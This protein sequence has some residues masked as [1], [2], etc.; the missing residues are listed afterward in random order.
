MSQSESIVSIFEQK[1]AQA[2]DAPAIRWNGGFWS[3]RELNS[4]ANQL[5]HLLI[6]SGVTSEAPVGIF[7]LRSPQTLMAFLAV[8]KAGGAYVPLDPTYP[9]DRIKYYIEDAAMPCVLVDPK[10]HLRFPETAARILVLDEKLAAEKPDSNP[11]IASG[12]GSLAHILYTSGST[13]RP[14]GVLVE[15]RGIIRLTQNVDY[16]T[17]T[18]SDVFLQNAPLSF[19][20]SSF[21][22]WGAL[23][24]GAC[25]AVPPSGKSTLS[26][27]ASAIRSFGITTTVMS[28]GLFHLL[29]EQELDSL[30]SLK[31]LITGGEVVSPSHAE[32]FLQRYPQAHLLNAYGP[33]ENSVFSTCHDIR[34]EKPMPTRLS[35]GRPIKGGGV[36]ILDDQL[37]PVKAGE[38]GELVLTGSGLARGYLNQPE[39]TAQ[40]FVQVTDAAGQSVRAY[41][42]GDLGSFLPDGSIDFHG[43]KDDQVKINGLRIEPGEIRNLLQAYPGVSAAEVMPVE[44]GGRK[45][46]EIFA[47]LRPAARVDERVLREFLRSKVPGNW[48][49]PQIR[50]LP[51]MPLN[52]NGKVD[53]AALRTI[54]SNDARSTAIIRLDEPSD[55]VEKLVWNVWREVLPGVRI[56][57][58]DHFADLGG[59]SLS[60]LDMMARLEK[61]VGRPIGLRPLLEGGTVVDLADAVREAGPIAEPPL[62]ICTQAGSSARAP[63]FFAHGDYICGGLYCQRIAHRLD[64]DQPFYSLAPQGTFGG[65]LPM[66]FEESA[67]DYVERIRSIQPHGPYYLGG[68][69]NGA[70]VMYEVAQQ[71]S[72]A[73]ETVAALVL[74][75]PPDL[76][77][78]LLRRKVS[79]FGRLIGL[80]DGK[81]R[82]IYQRIAEGIEVWQYYGFWQLVHDFWVRFFSYGARRVKALIEPKNGSASSDAPNL[83][84]HYYEVMAGYEPKAFAGSKSVWVILRRGESERSPRQMTYWSGFI[85]DVHFEVIPGTHLELQ[86]SMGEIA[87]IIGRALDNRPPGPPETEL[88]AEASAAR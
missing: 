13:G 19:D 66:T 17:I 69:C 50:L 88:A 37:Q 82:A 8:L 75:D 76:Y 47:V 57:R 44:S 59:S 29:V 51:G 28:A 48:L 68:F 53:R 63:F 73:G 84:F 60:A 5:A 77:F 83:N 25:V 16:V 85:P 35:I 41:R 42:S 70:V 71:L 11:G 9:A 22:I 54:L 34:L 38:E 6:E 2:P 64:A 18:P 23:L 12:P 26:D 72:R 20:I 78:F 79:S 86:T 87:Q 15:Q 24:N 43:R 14:K 62:M 56:R 67:A 3:Y 33:T 58:T 31:Y 80:P 30:A 45:Q 39:L 7:A 27:L 49:P 81:S 52:S 40:S 65:R 55:P 46:L 36:M 21:E 4:Q 10:E 1:V 32:R 61:V 74:L